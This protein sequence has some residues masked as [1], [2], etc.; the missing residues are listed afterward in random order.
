[1]IQIKL[2]PYASCLTLLKKNVNGWCRGLRKN[3]V[4]NIIEEEGTSEGPF[5]DLVNANNDFTEEDQATS[6]IKEIM[7][8]TGDY[9]TFKNV[10]VGIQ[11]TYG[12]GPVRG[13]KGTNKTIFT[14]D[15]QKGVFFSQITGRAINNGDFKSFIYQLGFR[16]NAGLELC[17]P[18]LSGI[19]QGDQFT[20]PPQPSHTTDIKYFKANTTNDNTLGSLSVFMD[21]LKP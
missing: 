11:T 5:G 15:P 3:T 7:I 2:V 13:N 14:A 12:F 17:D 21:T 4:S 1:M 10:V 9:A 20:E 18:P 8:Y 16:S 19:P 6:A